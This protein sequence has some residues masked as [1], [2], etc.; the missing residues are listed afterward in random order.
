MTQ[1]N[2]A[3]QGILNAA[4]E[5]LRDNGIESPRLCAEVLLSHQLKKTRVELYLEFDQPLNP[6]EIAGYRSLIRRRLKREPLQYIIGHQ[7]FW[8][9]DFL[10]SPGVLIPRPETE[11][12]VEEAL[13][14]WKRNLF[15]DSRHPKILDLGTGSGVIA[16]SLAKE[17]QNATLWASDISFKALALAKDNA[18]HHNLNRRITFRQGDLWQPFSNSSVSFDL[19]LSN[20]PYIPSEAFKALPPEVRCYEPQIA[21]DGHEN[22]MYFIKKIIEESEMYLKPGGWLLI[23]MDPNQT[24]IALHHIDSTQSFS[25]KE[26]RMDYRKKYRL[27]MAKKRVDVVSK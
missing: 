16:I 8:S 12:L 2:W 21:L 24:E 25:Y 9:L 22:G 14:L 15:S 5:F 3:I 20:P 13:K 23:E 19:I 18:Y 6:L 1:K 17:I 26:R 27:V 7:E 11:L 10:V 4:T